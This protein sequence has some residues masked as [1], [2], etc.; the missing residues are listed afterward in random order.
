[1][2][3]LALV[4]FGFAGI[5]LLL[6]MAQCIALVLHLRRP[7]PVATRHPGISVLKPLCGVDDDLLANLEVFAHLDYSR[8]EVLLGVRDANDAAYPVAR[9]AEQLW[10]QVMRVVIQRG[11]PGINPKVNQL[12]TLAAAAKHDILV[13]NDSNVRVRRN[14]LAEIAAYFE[15]PRVGL[16]THPPAGAGEQRLGALLDNLYLNTNTAPG[17]VAAKRI[18]RKDFVVSKSMALRREDLNAIGGF[19]AVKDV[20]AEDYV[21][22]QLVS[23]KLRKEIVIACSPITNVARYRSVSEFVARY[24]RWAVMQRRVV[25]VPIYLAELLLNPVLLASLALVL[26]RD[27][28]GLELWVMSCLLK[29]LIDC[30]AVRS[31]RGGPFPWTL[32]PFLPLKDLLAAASWSYGLLSNTIDW[33]GNRLLVLAE[34]RIQPLLEDWPPTMARKASRT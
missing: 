34:T 15:N 25:G 8:Y 13:V 7:T 2:T 10:P 6:A 1:M 24:A 11:E 14:Y 20:L 4:F 30:I 26:I 23:K 33:R 9:W 12:I 21:T 28:L 22:G 16:V 27:R 32:I 18:L 31:L 5:G 29:A 17:V 19:E 3:A